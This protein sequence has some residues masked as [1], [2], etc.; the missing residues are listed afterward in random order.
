MTCGASGEVEVEG[1]NSEGTA[2]VAVPVTVNC[3]QGGAGLASIEIF[4]GPPVYKADYETGRTYGQIPMLLP[5]DGS[6]PKTTPVPWGLHPLADEFRWTHTAWSPDDEGFVTAIWRKR[7][8]VAVAVRHADD[9]RVPNVVAAIDLNRTRTDLPEIYRETHSTG[10]AFITDIVFDVERRLYAR[11]AELHVSVNSGDAQAAE[12]VALFGEEVPP[13]SVTWIPI[14]LEDIPE[15]QEID[16]EEAMSVG[17][18]PWWPIGDYETGVGPTMTYK[19]DEED[20]RED[21]PGIRHGSAMSQLQHHRLLHACGAQEIYYGISNSEAMDDAGLIV[22]QTATA[23][24]D[25]WLAFSPGVIDRYDGLSGRYLY[26][27][28]AHEMGHMFAIRHSPCN[29]PMT[30]GDMYPYEGAILGA[31][32]SLGFRGQPL[33]RS[34]GNAGGGGVE[35]PAFYR[36]PPGAE[37]ADAMSYCFPGFVSDFNYQRAVLL[38]QSVD[39]W[40]PV[41]TTP[42]EDCTPASTDNPAKKLV[43]KSATVAEAFRSMPFPD[44]WTRMASLPCA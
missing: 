44:R 20:L 3:L 15:E 41:E 7:A 25:R 40:K 4:Q 5:E 29:T 42:N 27:T 21:T 37:Y 22:P 17:V 16:A 19:Q 39:Y 36:K 10:E 8:S 35:I 6:A 18:V 38:R 9:T 12:R 11:G 13:L 31:A 30:E 1:T 26:G 2:R 23:A 43:L 14:I 33:C 28:E 34:I 24:E 32:R